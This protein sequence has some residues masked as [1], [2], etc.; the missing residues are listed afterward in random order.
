MRLAT[1]HDKTGIKELMREFRGE[2]DI[3]QLLG[4]E[5]EPYFDKL[6]DNIFAG[7]GRVFYEENKG[8]LMA[9]VFPSLWCDKTFVMHELAWYVKPE[10]RG[11]TTGY[12]LF[13]AYIEYGNELK[14]Q[15]RIK[16]FTLSKLDVSPNL[17]YARHG[18]RKKDENWIQ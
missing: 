18:F 7:Q 3:S 16:F 2:A 10:H 4:N 13:K 12:R 6:L 9:I 14:Q 8:L 5:N 17:N 11:G 15:G 1:R